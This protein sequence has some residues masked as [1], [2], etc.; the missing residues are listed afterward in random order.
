VLLKAVLCLIKGKELAG[1][2]FVPV[3]ERLAV[4]SFPMRLGE[5]ELAIAVGSNRSFTKPW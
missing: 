2:F 5:T 3:A 1:F 4:Q